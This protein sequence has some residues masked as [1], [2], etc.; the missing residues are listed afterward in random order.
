MIKTCV[1]SYWAK[2][3]LEKNTYSNF[4]RKNDLIISLKLSVEQSRKYFDKIVFYG[5]HEAISQVC[6]FIEFDKVYDD[7]EILNENNVPH[8]L[9]NAPK[10]IACSKMQEPFILLEND[11]YLWDIPSNSHIFESDL[12][13][14]DFK[15]PSKKYYRCIESMKKHDLTV[16]PRWYKFAKSDFSI[17]KKDSLY[18]L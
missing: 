10:A 12:I 17:P 15:K 13:I 7:I 1:Y 11:F 8:Y 2:P 4:E 18:I 16:R 5:D 14:E 3:F 9:F 6:K